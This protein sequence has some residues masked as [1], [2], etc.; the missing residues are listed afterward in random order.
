VRTAA[1]VAN[2][3]D[4]IRA[5][6]R[7]LDPSV[8]PYGILTVE[9]RLGRTVA[10]RRLQMLLLASLAAVALMLSVI[11]AYGVVQQAVRSRTQEIGIRM[12]L[13]AN[14]S[15][16]LRIVLAGGLL[17]A[18]AGTVLGLIGALSL[19]RTL[20]TFLY[21]TNALDPL[22]FGT[23]MTMLLTVTTVACLAPALHAARV[24]PVRALRNE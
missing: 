19:N 3:R 10:L 23:V 6:M 24:D 11:G 4:A 9:E 14:A 1:N 22:I 17:P 5:E 13:G 21:E 2:V 12:A 20:A 18:F 16:V 8:P 7:A 15:K